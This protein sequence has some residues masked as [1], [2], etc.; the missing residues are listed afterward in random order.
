[1]IGRKFCYTIILTVALAGLFGACGNPLEGGSEPSGSIIRVTDTTVDTGLQ[2]LYFCEGGAVNYITATILLRNDDRPNFED[3][4]TTA[5]GTASFVTMNRYRI[6][7]A[8]L[9]MSATLPG[10]DGAGFSFGMDP[11]GT[12][13]LT[14]AVITESVLEHI[15]SNYP[16]V[17]NGQAMEVRADITIW[18]QDAFQVQVSAQATATFTVD[19]F[20]PCLADLPPADESS[21][22]E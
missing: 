22:S 9:N 10:I 2:D 13:T 1:M 12:G 18:G 5:D 4:L 3:Q 17:G 19:D 16:E 15:R 21:E 14:I 7:Y 11:G 6:D 8:V 20:N